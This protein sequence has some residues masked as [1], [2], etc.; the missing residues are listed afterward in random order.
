MN[1]K[2]RI[3]KYS[4]SFYHFKTGFIPSILHNNY[5]S[6]SRRNIYSLFKIHSILLIDLVRTAS[7]DPPKITVSRL[8]IS[9]QY[10]FTQYC[11]RK[12]Y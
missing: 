9:I 4:K 10:S 2:H 12:S 3:K 1:K 6:K 5:I 8:G 11:T 7:N